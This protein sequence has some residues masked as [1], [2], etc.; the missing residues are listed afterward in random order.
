MAHKARLRN[1]NRM[2]VGGSRLIWNRPQ[3]HVRQTE[4]NTVNHPLENLV[5]SLGERKADTI[6]PLCGETVVHWTETGR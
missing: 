4:P 2:D 6:A 3:G 1:G 5:L